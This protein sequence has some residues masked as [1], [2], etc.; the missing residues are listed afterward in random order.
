VLET[1]ACFP[2][3][4]RQVLARLDI[5]ALT[6]SGA[7]LKNDD[8]IKNLEILLGHVNTQLK[9]GDDRQS[10]SFTGVLLANFTQYFQPAV[11]NEL[12]RNIKHVGLDLWL[13]LSH[14]D[15][16]TEGEARA[17]D[18]RQ[19]HGLVYKNAT[20][21]PD[22]DRQ[23]FFQMTA[24]R[25]VMRSVAA[26]RVSHALVVWEVVDNDAWLNYAVAT[27]TH[28]WCTFTSALCWIGHAD[29]LVDAE[30]ALTRSVAAKP[31]GALMWLKDEEN[32][33]A[34]DLWRAN[35]EVS[36]S[37]RTI[38]SRSVPQINLCGSARLDRDPADFDP[39]LFHFC[40]SRC[41]VRQFGVLCPEPV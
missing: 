7:S 11:V 16:L 25:A 5:P 22:G 28:N 31:L 19:I 26:Q 37:R 39:D 23:N 10:S 2:V 13:E 27:R 17:L 8:V 18:M 15:Y 9:N 40:W 36:R 20:I 4:S 29:A 33:A 41:A 24:M 21:R 6:Q 32:M 38:L 12:A 34:H 3:T 1:L 35:D 14:P 30:A